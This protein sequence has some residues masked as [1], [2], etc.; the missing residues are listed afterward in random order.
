M[1]MASALL[2]PFYKEKLSFIEQIPADCGLPEFA[3]SRERP[4]PAEVS[5][6]LDAVCFTAL[7]VKKEFQKN[8]QILL[9]L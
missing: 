6:I 8:P 5:K 2:W 4:K 1:R 7:F 9:K 3:F